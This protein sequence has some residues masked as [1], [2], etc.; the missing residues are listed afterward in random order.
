MDIQI[1]L[2]TWFHGLLMGTDAFGNRY[3][4][5]KS[6]KRQARRWVIY[7]GKA[8]ASKVPP[9]WNAWLQHTLAEPPVLTATH[10]WEKPHQRNLTGTQQAHHP[11]IQHT[12]TQ[13][14]E[15]WSPDNEPQA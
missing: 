1:R 12:K 15:A 10:S 6:C 5:H 9:L 14:Y 7:H 2:L 11:H 4:Q 8:E 13:H 3:Y